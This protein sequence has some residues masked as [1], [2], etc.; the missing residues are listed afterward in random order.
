MNEKLFT[1]KACRG[2]LKQDEAIVSKL[3]YHYEMKSL[4]SKIVPSK[5]EEDNLE[6][7]LLAFHDAAFVVIT[8]CRRYF[9]T[10]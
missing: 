7:Y 1:R 9:E 5:R 10:F 6:S 3:K 8:G 2:I 4:F